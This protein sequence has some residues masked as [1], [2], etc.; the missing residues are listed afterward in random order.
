[1]LADK[2]G[3]VGEERG[4]E[5]VLDAGDVESSVFSER[6]IAV[7]E[8]REEGESGEQELPCGGAPVWRWIGV[9]AEG[10]LRHAS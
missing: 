9:G 6:M 4:V 10:K 7:D 1:M 2:G 3:V 5:G 8:E